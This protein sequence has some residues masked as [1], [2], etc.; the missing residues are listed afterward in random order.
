MWGQNGI[1][2]LAT[3]ENFRELSQRDMTSLLRV[4]DMV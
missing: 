2:S 4:G 1:N 3:S